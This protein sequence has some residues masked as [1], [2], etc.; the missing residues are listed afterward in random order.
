MIQTIL[1]F[2]A[3]FAAMLVNVGSRFL[4]S[5]WIPFALA[6]FIAYWIGHVVNFILS[7]T[8]VFKGKEERNTTTTFLKFTLVACV[9]LAVT[10][11]VSLL[12]RLLLEKAFPFWNSEIRDTIAHLMGIGCSFVFNY[13]GHLFFSFKNLNSKNNIKEDLKK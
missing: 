5:K 2:C 10:F 11:I 13:I 3:A 4:L 7:N 12:V 1:Y 6:V 8:I 9:G